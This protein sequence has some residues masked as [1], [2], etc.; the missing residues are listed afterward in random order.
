MGLWHVTLRFCYDFLFCNRRT[1]RKYFE[2]R[3]ER[4][5][6]NLCTTVFDIREMPN[7]KSPGFQEFEARFRKA[8][9][10]VRARYLLR[11]TSS[12]P[13]RFGFILYILYFSS[14]FP[15]NPIS[16]FSIFLETSPSMRRFNEV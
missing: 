12:N 9:F 5:N 16:I 8:L 4:R 10:F 7:F 15:C 1:V 2:M 14:I 3:R 6:W 11:L 13:A